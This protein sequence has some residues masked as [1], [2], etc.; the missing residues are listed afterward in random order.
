MSGMTR[1]R[2]KGHTTGTSITRPANTTTYTAGDVVGSDP[3]AVMTFSNASFGEFDSG[4]IQQAIVTSSAYV[5]TGPALE[6]W[7]FD[8]TVTADTDNAVFTPTDAEMATLVGIISF[9]S[10][11][12]KSG[13]ATAGAGGNMACVADNVSIP[14]NTKKGTSDLFG[15]LVARNAY[16][17]VSGEIFTVR[18]QVLD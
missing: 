11:D 1:V 12:W 17:P 2:G 4:I 18:L 7:L 8:T 15:V 16:V 6:L 14:F 9:A 5:A 10:A 13:T 3:G